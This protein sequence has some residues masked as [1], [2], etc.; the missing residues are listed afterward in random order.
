M[1]FETNLRN[2][3]TNTNFRAPSPWYVNPSETPLKEIVPI[4]QEQMD[5]LGYSQNIH[6]SSVIR[7][8]PNKDCRG[9]LPDHLILPK[10]SDKFVA[11]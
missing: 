8:D 11:G 6:Y 7:I 2:Y 1:R 9:K 10:F 3:P 4:S 5:D